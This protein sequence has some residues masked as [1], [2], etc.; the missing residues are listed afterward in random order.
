MRKPTGAVSRV[1]VSQC[2]VEKEDDSMTM[3]DRLSQLPL[4]AA[5][6]IVD[7]RGAS[8]NRIIEW[9]QAELTDLALELKGRGV[10]RWRY[11]SDFL[12]FQ[13]IDPCGN[14]SEQ[15]EPDEGELEDVW[16]EDE[17]MSDDSF[18]QKM[19]EL[20]RGIESVCL[21]RT[22]A[23]Q[24]L[25]KSAARGKQNP[26]TTVRVIFVTDSSRPASL[27]SA[28]RCAEYLKNHA[29]KRR[30]AGQ[31]PLL[32]TTVFCL[33]RSAAEELPEVLSQGLKRNAAWKHL[34]LLILGENDHTEAAAT[35]SLA[36]IHNAELLLYALIMLSPLPAQAPSTSSHLNE[37]EIDLPANTF[38]ASLITQEYAARWVRHWLQSGL[39]HELIT[40]LQQPPAHLAR[41]ENELDTLASE[42]FR[43][44]HRRVQE[45]IPAGVSSGTT[46]L[47]GIE[48]ARQV[49][50]QKPPVF[51]QEDLFGGD[52]VKDLESYLDQLSETYTTSL[53][54]ST[55]HD[56]HNL[57]S[58]Q[59][60]QALQKKGQTL[61]ELEKLQNEAKQILGSPQ[62]WD[63]ASSFVKSA[64]LFLEDLDRLCSDLQQKHLNNP[65][66]PHAPR[67]TMAQRQRDLQE[68]GQREIKKFRK[69]LS[70]WPLLTGYPF[71][72]RIVQWLTSALLSS[73][74][75]I[76]VFLI[77]TGLHHFFL[78]KTPA[79][80]SLV[81]RA[82][83]SIPLLDIV[84]FIA[85][86]ALIIL[87]RLRLSPRFPAGRVGRLALEAYLLIL[88]L[89]LGLG[90]FGVNTTL[91]ALSHS[92]N[93]TTS[94]FYLS[95]LSFMQ[96]VTP[97]ALLAPVLV[98]LVELFYWNW[99]SYRL[100]HRYR[101]IVQD[102]HRRHE[103]DIQDVIDFLTDDVTLAMAQQAELCARPGEPGPYVNRLHDLAKLLSDLADK[104]QTQEQLTADRLLLTLDEEPQGANDEASVPREELELALLIDE[105][106]ELREQ[107]KQ[108]PP[109]L[110][111]LAEYILRAEGVE[112]LEELE[113]SLCKKLAE[114]ES[115]QQPLQLL[116][117]S[118]VATIT[119]FIID[120]SP[121]RNINLKKKV[122][123]STLEYI[124]KEM[125]VLNALVEAVNN[126]ISRLTIL[127]SPL[128]SGVDDKHKQANAP[129]ALQMLTLWS[130]Q[131]WQQEGSP[132]LKQSLMR[133]DLLKHPEQKDS[134]AHELEMG[135]RHLLER[136]RLFE[137]SLPDRQKI[138]YYLLMAPPSQ[139]L[140]TLTLPPIIG[141]PD[142]ERLLLFRIRPFAATA[143]A[144]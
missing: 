87:V 91:T 108:R 17:E 1:S 78:E 132:R 2:T 64:C 129:I 15:S 7:M 113:Q 27:S 99:W 36:H 21:Y 82:V 56:A 63:K 109:L 9:L 98:I 4:P 133:D 26:D 16:L 107:I 71:A 66:N 123:Q 89:F 30:S 76:T 112:T 23:L 101:Q 118:L 25:S 49:S 57:G 60:M 97:I 134:A 14:D 37:Q 43:N 84:A 33:N 47:A 48:R 5:H 138:S 130:Q 28:A 40:V 29:G 22:R 131:F 136:A 119:R 65:L 124:E 13:R 52:A 115:D 74:I 139:S 32:C 10:P 93:D 44:W 143:P 54:G 125:P 39:T 73:L 42:W 81:D 104:A 142:T 105:H 140:K 114:I 137:S 106:R 96:V 41:E 111:V 79:L 6:L 45:A 68:K 88:L 83:L 67:E 20:V 11:L 116:L 55:L 95:W 50:A 46:A 8:D 31:Q 90:G 120:P 110:R 77:I 121:L 85:S 94:I 38:V 51:R 102:L 144:D 80:L 122:A 18:E 70:R 61:G 19:Q 135:L 69:D 126:Q 72:R 86:F 3:S 53:N 35:E 12:S 127:Q 100:R 58:S 62:F 24:D 92:P 141:I 103:R 128:G 59:I 117:I 34:D 75:V